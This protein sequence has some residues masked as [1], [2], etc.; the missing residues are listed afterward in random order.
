M[1]SPSASVKLNLVPY[2]H[3]RQRVA[4][5]IAISLLGTRSWTA[6]DDPYGEQWRVPTWHCGRPSVRQRIS[7]T[8]FI[9]PSSITPNGVPPDH[10]S[11]QCEDW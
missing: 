8:G 5:V 7:R 4:R 10:E 3:A 9:P 1:V 2:L 11:R 6:L